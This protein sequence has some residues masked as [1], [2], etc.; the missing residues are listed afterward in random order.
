MDQERRCHVRD[1]FGQDSGI[2][3]K[4]APR[5]FFWLCGGAL[6]TPKSPPRSE[7]LRAEKKPLRRPMYVVLAT[8]F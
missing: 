7:K 3:W 8:T 4:K 2:S 1:L 6:Y 5:V